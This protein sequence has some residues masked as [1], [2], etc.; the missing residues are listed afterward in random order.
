MSSSDDSTRRAAWSAYWSSGRM[1]SCATSYG[2]NY[3]GAIADFWRGFFGR[4][5]PA[6]RLLDLATG[7]GPL[8]HMLWELRKDA[9]DI[10]AVDLAELAPAWH[11][12]SLHGGVRFHS[13]VRI[14][15]LPFA[16]AS[17]DGVV[18]QFGFEY[19]DRARALAEC[20]RVARPQAHIAF[21]MHHAGSVLVKVGREELGHHARLVAEDGLMHAA[22]DA[23]PWIAQARSG[24]PASDP[25]AAS[26]ARDCYNHAMEALAAAAHASL[27]P[28]LLLE[29]REEVHRLLAS[30]R[31]G[32][33][34]SVLADLDAYRGELERGRLRT[35][36]MVSHALDRSQVEQL[37]EQLQSA[38]P[39]SSVECR[40]LSQSE[41]V[42][43][44]SLV[45][46]PSGSPAT[47][48]V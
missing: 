27:A 14:E 38:R 29:A 1:H 20:Q 35:A 34:A 21:V 2:N 37:R 6:G 12:P 23:I 10:D 19:A 15:A 5:P 31:A 7:N 25:V 36:E 45:S 30:V 46:T 4:F 11:E 44:W 33:A 42:L 40:E 48:D 22:H 18:S 26:R 28:D 32:N 43:A 17:F 16:D 13:A 24:V 9:A 47:G 39:G 41:G 3:G 8:P